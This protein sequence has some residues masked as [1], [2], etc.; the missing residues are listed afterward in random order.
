MTIRQLEKILN[1]IKDEDKDKKVC[2]SGYY[3]QV[4]GYFFD[5]Q[6]GEEAL[7]LTNNHVQPISDNL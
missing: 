5:T 2:M 3:L 4:N 7:I 6:D 1:S